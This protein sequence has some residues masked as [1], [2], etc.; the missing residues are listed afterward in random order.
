M[1]RC[2]LWLSQLSQ[3][4]HNYI[5]PVCNGQKLPGHSQLISS[6]SL[7]TIIFRLGH[8]HSIIIDCPACAVC[9]VQVTLLVPW[10]N[11]EDQALVF[12]RIHSFE[13]PEEQTECI[14]DWVRKRTGFEAQ[15]KIQYY[16]GRYDTSLLGIF[17]I[18]DLTVYIPAEEV[19]LCVMGQAHLPS[20]AQTQ[21]FTRAR[22]RAH[23]RTQ[24][25]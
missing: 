9:F 7:Q 4:S 5:G 1:L 23:R 16:P 13:Q 12:H 14:K 11:Q 10:L 20:H 19:R 17:P 6:V 24:M 25:P 8:S 15:F 21:V 2:D 18:G 3:R 22:V